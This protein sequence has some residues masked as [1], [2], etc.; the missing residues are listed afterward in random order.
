MTGRTRQD[1]D[2]GGGPQRRCIAGSGESDPAR[3]VRFVVGPD[4]TM[5]PDIDERLPGRGF[6][7][8]AS[9]DMV[10]KACAKNLFARAARAPVRVPAD[11]G[12]RIEQLLVVRCQNLIGLARRAGQAAFGF[13]K[14]RGWLRA[15]RCGVAI[16]ALD[17]SPAA[18]AK[19][20]GGTAGETC[21]AVLRSDEIGA[22]IGRDHIVHAMVAEGRLGQQLRREMTRLAGF[23]PAAAAVAAS[24]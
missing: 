17:G 4:G 5:V 12:D 13:E 11:L 19:L 6:W 22:A 3:L 21:L 8:S 24:S 10:K 1:A 20:Y 18:R 14:V 2:A 15:G 23:R 16:E 9:R 7:L